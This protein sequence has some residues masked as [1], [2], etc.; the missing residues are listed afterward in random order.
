MVALTPVV[1]ALV[2]LPLVAKSVVAVSEVADA[3]LRVVL[4]ETVSAV[5]EALVRVV[6][7]LTV[8]AVA[9]ALVRVLNPVDVKLVV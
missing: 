9:E 4:P 5:A 7:P 6:C 8:S 2:I 1:D 3:L